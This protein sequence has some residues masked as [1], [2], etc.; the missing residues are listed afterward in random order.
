M[1][2]EINQFCLL[3]SPAV[4]CLICRPGAGD[5]LTHYF[6]G[7]ILLEQIR[8]EEH[9]NFEEAQQELD[10]AIAL[11]PS[12]PQARL[13]MGK[14]LRMREDLPAARAQFEAAVRLDP[15]SSDAYYQLM[16]VYQKLG[17]QQKADEALQK[18]RELKGRS[19]ENTN[20]KQ[21]MTVLGGAGK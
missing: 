12:L 3:I 15:K 21:V 11:N 2:S 8:G 16:S 9:H 19:Q 10:K 13:E 20:Q 14:L 7:K 18:F 6:Y 4:L 1:T 5:A 17:D